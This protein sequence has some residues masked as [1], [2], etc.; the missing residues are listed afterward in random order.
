MKLGK[1]K[2]KMLKIKSNIKSNI[3]TGDILIQKN[4]ETK[5]V[6]FVCGCSY[7][8]PNN[9]DE[10]KVMCKKHNAPTMSWFDKNKG[11]MN[12]KQKRTFESKY[13][14]K[15]KFCTEQRRIEGNNKI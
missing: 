13:F 12:R 6:I 9:S 3:P 14:K 8:L 4:N 5:K 11:N 2:N 7:Q 15:Y 1:K 10:N